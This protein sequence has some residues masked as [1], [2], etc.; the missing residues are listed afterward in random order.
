MTIP[1]EYRSFGVREMK[2]LP[3]RVIFYDGHCAFCDGWVAWLLEHDSRRRFRYAAL[4]GETA[5]EL[6]AVFPET[7]AA[8]LNSLILLDSSGPEPLVYLRSRAVFRILTEL[9]R[10]YRIIGWLRVFPAV[11][12]DL[13]YR[14]IARI[15]YRIYGRLNECRA[16]NDDLRHLFLE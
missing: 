7:L 8:S 3:P 10:P 2:E 16:P 6:S 9:G 4:Q 14:V 5:R 1:L 13:P 12:T 11:I 15:R